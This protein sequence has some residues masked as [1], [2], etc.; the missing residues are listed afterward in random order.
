MLFFIINYLLLEVLTNK[1][2]T[3]IFFNVYNLP[4]NYTLKM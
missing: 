2:L 3:E 4:L 1:I